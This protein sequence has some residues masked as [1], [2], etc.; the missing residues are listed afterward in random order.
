MGRLGSN[1]SWRLA[2]QLDLTFPPVLLFFES[3]LILC[4]VHRSPECLRPR[5]MLNAPQIN[6]RMP[7]RPSEYRLTGECCRDLCLLYK[8][9]HKQAPRTSPPSCLCL[10]CRFISDLRPSKPLLLDAHLLHWKC[11]TIKVSCRHRL[12]LISRSLLIIRYLE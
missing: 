8:A 11:H 4:A 9:M 6:A 12:C 5:M 2:T 7:H 3:Q 1:I 10:A